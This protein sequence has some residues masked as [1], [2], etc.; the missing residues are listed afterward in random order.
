VTFHRFA[1]RLKFS[2]KMGDKEGG[3]KM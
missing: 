3:K 2:I 1:L